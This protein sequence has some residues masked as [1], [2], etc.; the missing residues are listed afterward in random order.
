MPRATP[1]IDANLATAVTSGWLVSATATRTSGSVF[2]TS[3]FSAAIVARSQTISGTVFNDVN[4]DSTVSVG[5]GTFANA[6][7]QLYVDDLDGVIDAGDLLV[8]SA[9]TAAGG[10]YTFSNLGNATYW[11]VVD[12]KTLAATAYNGVFTINDVWAEQTYGVA[13]AASGRRLP[14][15]RRHALRRPER[16]DV[17]QHRGDRDRRARHARHCPNANVAG[18]DSGF[19]FN[20]VTNTRGG[21]TVSGGVGD[22]D[23]ANPRTVQGSLRQFIQNANAITGANAMRFVPASAPNVVTGGVYN[24]DANYGNDG[25]DDWWRITVSTALPAITDN[26]GTTIDG[27]AY[28][29]FDG[30]TLANTNTGTVGYVGAVGLGADGIA[31]TG[32]DPA[33]LSGVIKP[34][35]EIR[36]V[37]V[38]DLDIGLEVR[39]NNATI[40]AISIHG[41][42]TP[43][44]FFSDGDIVVGHNFGSDVGENLTGILIEDN[45][46]G[47][48]PAALANPG[49]ASVS[50][51]AVFGADGGTIRRNAIAWAEDFGIFLT[52]NADGWTV[53]RNDIRD[54]GQAD[55][56]HDGIDIGNLSGGAIVTENYFFSNEGVGVDS[57]RSDGSNT[58]RDNT[59]DANSLPLPAGS[60][61]AGIRLFGTGS[62][63]SQNVIR[64]NTGAGVLV[65]RQDGS[66]TNT[67]AT[68]N[69][70]TRNS[71]SNNTGNAIDL[72]GAAGDNNLGDGI[73]LNDGITTGAAGNIGVDFPVITL[74]G[75]N[76]T[77]TSISG[78]AA[79]GVTSV[80]VY[81]AVAA[82]A[83]DANG[84]N[85]YGEGVQYLGTAA[86]AGGAWTLNFTDGAVTLNI[87]DAVSA[88]GT[89][90]ANNTSEFGRNVAVVAT[91]DISGTIW[92]DA[93]ADADVS[94]GDGTTGLAGVAVH[95]FR[96][97]AGGG[98]GTPDGTDVWVATTTTDASGVYTFT[99]LGNA[100]YWVAVDSKTL[101]ANTNVWGEQ[102]Y[103]DNFATAAVDLDAGYGGRTAT[104]SDNVTAAPASLATAEHLARAVVAGANVAGLD[105][106]FSFNV[107]TNLLRT[108]A[109]GDTD[110]DG[111]NPR[112]IQ[113]SLY[114]FIQNA[115]ALAGDNAMRF[116]PVVM[117]NQTA[118][119]DSWWQISVA[120]ALPQISDAG[121]TID[122]TAYFA[123]ANGGVRDTNTGSIGAGGVVGTGADGVTGTGDE[124]ALGQVARPELEIR[125]GAAVLTSIGVGLDVNAANVGIE[126]LSIWGFGTGV[127]GVTGQV[128]VRNVAGA[129]IERNIIGT[130]P[131]D[132]IDPVA[133]LRGAGAGIFVDSGDNGIVQNNLIGFNGFAGIHLAPVSNS[134]NNW[135]ILGNEIRGNGQ[136]NALFDGANLNGPGGN[137]VVQGNLIVDNRSPGID[138]PNASGTILIADNSITGNAAAAGAEQ[139][140]I[141]IRGGTA[142]TT[143]VHNVISGN[144]GG[145]VVVAGTGT[146]EITQNSIFGNTGAPGLGIDLRL[147][148]A[149][150][151]DG[152]TPNDAGDGD[153]G[154]NAR[155]NYPVLTSATSDLTTVTVTGHFALTDG[156][157]TLPKHQPADRVLLQRHRRRRRRALSRRHP[158]SRPTRTAT[159]R[160][161]T[162]P[163]RR[164]ASRTDITSP[165]PPRSTSAAATTATPPSSPSPT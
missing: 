25:G 85:N 49:D 47:S 101:S 165:R 95:L 138:V 136:L 127:V 105:Y 123:T 2:T 133:A 158:R 14:R 81:R 56:S 97:T 98:A 58:I 102:T 22:D 80:E 78:T 129:A 39:A 68:G 90:A 116:V 144:V 104:G 159:S 35:L 66:V 13:G 67:P 135:Q 64:N 125:N 124:V 8:T 40:R 87:G 75:K 155:Q 52:S 132:F 24:D 110:H 119:T 153:G 94:A 6:A 137:T 51:I 121:T 54:N 92:N 41:F 61:T 147:A 143:I 57:Y 11:V 76:G 59:I 120:T 103:G 108:G 15:R 114:Q 17:G 18:I 83:G 34:E 43:S 36:E 50:G 115:N 156:S 4:A 117:A 27:T 60:E 91:Y 69:R 157:R 3:E 16:R 79:T 149:T 45:V 70:I 19:S 46:I 151:G 12:S 142:D 112:T 162:C 38:G 1:T 88:I 33:A 72:N 145:G 84:G 96:D 55:S 148:S 130:G 48:G 30:V 154:G 32:D 139:T 111:A 109:A 10:T 7:V 77:T 99:G 74:A 73:T 29:R 150:V 23:T 9:T 161:R 20:V 146:A 63:V 82:G 44:D 128:V 164:P 26:A 107:V 21:D 53:T 141:L 163:S 152:V 31:G 126:D 65:A 89:T 134:P 122:G 42:G 28:S 62:T 131:H 37:V 118:G 5:E 113:G 160:S 106:G 71:F 100:T 140:G 93:D 86:V